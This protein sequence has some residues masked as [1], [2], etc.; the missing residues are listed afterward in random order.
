MTAITGIGAANS[1]RGMML[2]VPLI[3]QNKAFYWQD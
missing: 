3:E 2:V 1:P